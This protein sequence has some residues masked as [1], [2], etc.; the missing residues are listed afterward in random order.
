M[1]SAIAAALGSWQIRGSLEGR[2]DPSVYAEN[3]NFGK[4][5]VAENIVGKWLST[6]LFVYVGAA[7]VGRASAAIL[8]AVNTIFGP[9]RVLACAINAVLPIHFARSQAAG[10]RAALHAQLKAVSLL[11]VLLLGGFCLL[12]AIFADPLMR[13][14]YGEKYAGNASLV[15]LYATDY[16]FWYMTMTISAALCARRLTRL[17]FMNRLCVSLIAIPVG[18]YL[19]LTLGIYGVA[20]SMIA[21]SLAMCLLTWCLTIGIMREGV[22]QLCRPTRT[23]TT[24]PGCP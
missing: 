17:M 22:P 8:S 15:V 21:N 1:T 18:Y 16:C 23:T 24:A 9:T 4:W 14:F 12:L 6:E 19:I 11:A 5:L 10:G 7:V 3:W 20:L 13:V 2:I